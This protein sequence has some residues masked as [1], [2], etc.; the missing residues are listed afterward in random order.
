VELFEGPFTTKQNIPTRPAKDP[1]T[2]GTIS[3]EE[4]P[5]EEIKL[6]E[7]FARSVE[8]V[9]DSFF[10]AKEDNVEEVAVIPITKRTIPD[11]TPTTTTK[12]ISTILPIIR[13]MERAGFTLSES[14]D[15]VA[16]LP[17]KKLILY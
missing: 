4:V 15:A 17:N 13:K 6:S 1:I 5:F 14:V 3:I 2:F 11:K 9:R 10:S 8:S 7:S 12:I 16:T